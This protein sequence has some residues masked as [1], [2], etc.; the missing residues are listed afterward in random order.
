[1]SPEATP[2]AAVECHI[3]DTGHCL[4]HESMMLRG[5]R[6]ASVECHA[7]VALIRHPEHGWGLW[8][9]GYAPRMLDE[10]ARWPFS[11]Y[12]RATPLRLRP[13][14]AAAAQLERFGLRPADIGWIVL[15]HLHADHVAG[16]RDFPQARLILTAEAYAA[17]RG[18]DGWR[19]LRRAFI[20]RLLPDDFAARASLLPAFT[21]PALGALG[22]THDVWGDGSLILVGLPGHARGQVGM[23]VATAGRRI[24]LAAD[25]AWLSRAIREQRGPHPL[26]AIFTDD[27]RAV[28]ATLRKLHEF[29][30]QFPEVTIIPTHCPEAYAREVGR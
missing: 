11:L 25:G 15:S 22:P 5:G 30:R 26:T 21:G 17:V 16:L 14:L 2:P 19:A 3:L 8:D 10:T 20:P 28:L 18:L 7:L 4:A 12:R 24:L 9:A 27:R 23:L 13:E 29:A 1:M 6:F